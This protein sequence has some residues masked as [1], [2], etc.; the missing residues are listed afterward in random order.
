MLYT[1]LL[2]SFICNF[3][4][5]N[6]PVPIAQ[7]PYSL[8]NVF[9]AN[10][11]LYIHVHIYIYRERENSDLHYSFIHQWTLWLFLY[12]A[13]YKWCFNNYGSVIVYKTVISF[14]LGKYPGEELLSH[15]TYLFFISFGWSIIFFMMAPSQPKCIRPPFFST[16]SPTLDNYYFLYGIHPKMCKVLS[17]SGFDLHFLAE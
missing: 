11:P 1:K 2:D 14:P 13:Y 9:K 17:H 3:V 8:T 16:P 5:L 15:H 7:L 10:I 6:I 4:F 12:L